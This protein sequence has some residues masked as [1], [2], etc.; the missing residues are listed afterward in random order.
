V[1]FRCEGLLD[2]GIG[3]I[4]STSPYYDQ[5]LADIQRRIDHPPPEA[6]GMAEILRRGLVRTINPEKRSTSS[7][8][9]NESGKTIAALEAFWRSEDIRGSVYRNATVKTD[10][11]WLT[12][13][14]LLK[15]M[16]YWRTIMPGSTRYLG[17]D[18]VA[19]D[20]TDIRPPAPD[21]IWTRGVL[22][23][24]SGGGM[25]SRFPVKSVTLILDGVFFTDGE[26]VGPNETEFWEDVT[27][28][29]TTRLTIANAARDGRDRG[30]TAAEIMSRIEQ[31]TGPAPDHP[32]HPHEKRQRHAYEI[33][34]QRRHFDDER[35]VANLAVHA[36]AALPNFRKRST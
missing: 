4:P 20:N 36:G 31:I 8:L 25:I 24:G 10:P 33:A 11:I 29:T 14:P 1:E 12:P 3:L 22:G 18:G 21:E 9:V 26:F 13:P 35:I 17:E 27:I 5:L 32:P 34:G 6:A 2:A 7:I 23:G 16:T 28:D 30:E 15:I 19:G